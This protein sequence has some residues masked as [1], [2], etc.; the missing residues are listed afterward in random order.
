MLADRAPDGRTERISASHFAS[1]ALSGERVK[2]GTVATGCQVWNWILFVPTMLPG[3][4][5]RAS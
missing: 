3:H 5:A 2:K 1:S 4:C